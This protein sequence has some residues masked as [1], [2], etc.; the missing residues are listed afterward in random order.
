MLC[1]HLLMTVPSL[2]AEQQMRAPTKQDK[3][4]VCGMFV[5]K[6]PDWV[7]AMSFADGTTLFFDG[8]KDLFKYYLNTEGKSHYR[9][10]ADAVALMVT[11]YYALEL[12][13][14]RGAWFVVGS[15]VYGP[16]GHELVAFRSREDAQEFL[17]DHEGKRVL[18]FEEIT[19]EVLKGLE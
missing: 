15:N 9:K 13:D 7:S 12:I 6:Y 8:A 5:Y 4:P 14:A 10:A 19:A 1:M 2:A 3:C 11:E 17:Q 16:M 18:R